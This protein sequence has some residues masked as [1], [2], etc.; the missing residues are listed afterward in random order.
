MC[1]SQHIFSG[2]QTWYL[3]TTATLVHTWLIP[4]LSLLVPL[5]TE[6]LWVSPLSKLFLWLMMLGSESSSKFKSSK[7]I[8]SSMNCALIF[9]LMLL[10][11]DGYCQKWVSYQN[12]NSRFSIAIFRAVVTKTFDLSESLNSILALFS[13]P[14]LPPIKVL[15]NPTVNC[16]IVNLICK[17]WD[18]LWLTLCQSGVS[19]PT[20]CLRSCSFFFFFASS[21]R[22]I[23]FWAEI[24]KGLELTLV[25]WP[26]LAAGLLDKI[27]ELLVGINSWSYKELQEN[28][29]NWLKNFAQ[30]L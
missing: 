6:L 1:K 2:H 3:V 19:S 15:Q 5:P 27:P 29:N 25:N 23:C 17:C 24:N 13:S 4:L 26:G 20:I 7:S 12:Y 9:R 30:L 14:Q 22:C 16:Q 10:K 28:D 21:T 18:F 8:S 11:Q